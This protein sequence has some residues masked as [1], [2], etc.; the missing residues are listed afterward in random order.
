MN[1]LIKLLADG[2]FHSG[3][4][5]GKHLNVTRAAISKQIKKLAQQ[6]NL[7]IH[8]VTGKGYRLSMP[9]SLLDADRLNRGIIQ[10]PITLFSEIN[11][12]NTECFRLL[13]LGAKPPFI[14]TAEQQTAGKGRRG[15]P[16][17]S[18]YGQ[19]IYYSL[20]IPLD[21][22]HV[23]EGLSLTVGLAI[24]NT[25]KAIGLKQ[26]GLKWPNDI[27]LNNK[28]IC[29]ILLELHGEPSGECHVVIG[30][31]I[32]V[33]M[34]YAQEEAIDQPWTSIYQEVGDIIDRNELLISLSN[35][36]Q[37]YLRIHCLQ[38]FKAL[39]DEWQNNNL[40]QNKEV[41]LIQGE[42]SII[43]KMLGIDETGALK[44]L[45]NN[46]IQYFNAGEVS[47]RLASFEKNQSLL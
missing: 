19:N 38:G 25:L 7:S 15:R 44:L 11:S 12:T 40:W 9:L 10:W 30:I 21:G 24:L 23:I 33:N 20:L 36:L 45:I 46:E 28:K 37:H 43:G 8:R 26:I 16:W 27:L 29:G 5:L 35:S 17:F 14:I 31:G 32:N 42:T 39:K 18:P 47:L 3:E 34:P 41:K 22:S 6:T 2:K 4:E 13:K 1:T